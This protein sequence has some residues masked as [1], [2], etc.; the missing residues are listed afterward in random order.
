MLNGPVF[1]LEGCPGTV[2]V[3]FVCDSAFETC[4]P[5]FAN[6]T[7]LSLDETSQTLTMQQFNSSGGVSGEPPPLVLTMT[8][9]QI[10]IKCQ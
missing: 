5:F 10:T 9:G 7:M 4:G 8:Q 2:V 1:A 6:A 3:V